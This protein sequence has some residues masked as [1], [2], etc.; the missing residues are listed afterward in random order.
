MINL[1][2]IVGFDWDEGNR[3]KNWLKHRVTT[4]ECEEAFFNLPLLLQPDPS[5]SQAEHR[6][7]VL[8]QTNVGRYL[9]IAFT[10]RNDKIRVIS[11]REMS[12]KESAIYEQADS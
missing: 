7:F 8:G 6:Y 2:S 5:H 12:Q 10:T 3:E 11:A 1:N 9:F 4:S